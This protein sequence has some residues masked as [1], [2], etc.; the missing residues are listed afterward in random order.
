MSID[1]VKTRT[2][3]SFQGA[4]TFARWVALGSLQEVSVKRVGEHFQVVPP[5]PIPFA[6]VCEDYVYRYSAMHWCNEEELR[7]RLE[8]FDSKDSEHF[9]SPVVAWF[10]RDSGITW[11]AKRW[12][13]GR[14]TSNR[15]A[16]PQVTNLLGYAGHSDWRLPT[17]AELRTLTDEKRQKLGLSGPDVRVWSGDIDPFDRDEYLFLRLEGM[18]VGH[19]SFKEH[20]KDRTHPKDGYTESATTVFV[21]SDRQAE[22]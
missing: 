9:S 22:V 2:F 21:R 18:V 10:D 1:A 3:P 19:Q 5:E 4:A 7:R 20:Y 17:I 13:I 11:D 8:V 6:Q 16:Y 15:P 12:F 14:P